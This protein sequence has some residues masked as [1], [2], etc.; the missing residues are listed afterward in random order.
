[1]P[2]NAMAVPTTP[3]ATAQLTTLRRSSLRRATSGRSDSMG[4]PESVEKRLKNQKM[5]K[6]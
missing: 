4:P 1:M 2:T 6:R 5:A 3:N